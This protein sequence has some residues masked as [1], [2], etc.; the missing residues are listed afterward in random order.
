M[1]GAVPRQHM[2]WLD[3]DR[4]LADKIAELSRAIVGI[5]KLIERWGRSSDD[6]V[7]SV[8]ERI[9]NGPKKYSWEN[10]FK[11]YILICRDYA[12]IITN[13]GIDSPVAAS[14]LQV[15]MLKESVVG[16]DKNMNWVKATV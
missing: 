12:L 1:V 16:A 9:G 13:L 11:T 10:F 15:K 5:L 4:Q 14:K 8:T 2:A 3:Q 6:R 7:N